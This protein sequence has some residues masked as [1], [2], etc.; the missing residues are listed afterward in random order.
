MNPEDWAQFIE[1]PKFTKAWKKLGLD[2]VDM[3]GLQMLIM[4]SPQ[5]YPVIPGTGGLRKLRFSSGRWDRG[6]SGGVRVCYAYI[7]EASV[8]VLAAI[9][10]KGRKENISAGEKKVIK[11]ELRRLRSLLSREAPSKETD[12]G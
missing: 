4:A 3:K 1:L 8:V 11:A 5:G 9:Y 6:K 12:N 7:M 10:A 2:K